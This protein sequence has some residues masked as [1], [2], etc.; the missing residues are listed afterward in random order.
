MAIDSKVFNAILAMDSYNRGY[1]AGIVLT[2]TSVGEAVIDRTTS[3]L[4]YVDPNADPQSLEFLDQSVGFYAVAYNYNGETIIS[5]RGTNDDPG[6]F[7]GGYGTDINH[8]Y[9]IA[10][11]NP[12]GA[13]AQLALDF[14][15]LVAGGIGNVLTADISLTGH[16]MGAGIAAFV[17]ALYG[18]DADVFDNMPYE[19]AAAIANDGTT[20]SH[21]L[22]GSTDTSTP[23]Y[24]QLWNEIYGVGVTKWEPDFSGI[25]NY[26]I[27]EQNGYD[28]F[29]AYL[30]DGPLG[31]LL[32]INENTNDQPLALPSGTQLTW[33]WENKVGQAHDSSLIVIRMFG[34]TDEAK[35]GDNE[36]YWDTS[37]KYWMP[38]LFDNQLALSTGGFSELTGNYIDN[39]AWSAI[40]K[41]A[42]AYSAL[43]ADEN[44]EGLVFG[45]TGIRALYNDANDLGEAMEQTNVSNLLNATASM[46]SQTFVQYAGQ[47]AMGGVKQ[48]D[49]AEAL[50]GVL[51]LSADSGALALDF[52]DAMWGAG[53]GN[54]A[55]PDNR[56]GIPL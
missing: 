40:T 39:D 5:Y 37:A 35:V 31:H 24:Q 21:T 46:I 9:T 41:T 29:L 2:T 25:T 48:A 44:G 13:Q 20:S 14:Y 30:R 55:R 36:M 4:G 6:L 11:G 47:L 1:N 56:A 12:T 50:D 15:Q 18:K 43:E 54:C 23:I 33:T 19:L 28:N 53:P 10:V 22:W 16:S 51:T 52:S 49:H 42:I 26:Y 3:D 32:S 27:P 38:Q 34:D 17:A 8:G 7:G 45:D